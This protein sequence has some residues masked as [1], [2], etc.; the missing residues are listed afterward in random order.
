MSLLHYVSSY[1]L[2]IYVPDNPCLFVHFR[3]NNRSKSD[4]MTHNVS[5][6]AVRQT[7]KRRVTRAGHTYNAVFISTVTHWHT[8]WEDCCV[9]PV[10][11]ASSSSTWR[12]HVTLSMCPSFSLS[13]GRICTATGLRIQNIWHTYDINVYM[14]IAHIVYSSVIRN[15]S[16]P[17]WQKNT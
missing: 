8:Q 9:K 11:Q 15:E 1:S 13:L 2:Q 10:H 6:L 3:A 17:N 14:H 16:I 12:A 4:K 7:A 5:I